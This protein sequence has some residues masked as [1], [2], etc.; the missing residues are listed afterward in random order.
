VTPLQRSLFGEGDPS[1][2]DDAAF[3]RI[4][5]DERA[6]VDVARAYLRGSDTLFD[7]LV[8]HVAW[9][10]GQRWMYER[11]VDD[12]RLSRW[13][14]HEPFPHRSLADTKKA[15]QRRY[16][17]P[18]GGVG[19]NYYRDGRDSVAFHRDREL[20]HLDDT[21]ICI[22][23]LGAQRPFLV[24]PRGGGRSLDLSPASGDLLV[25]G[26]TCQVDWEHGV[27]KVARAGPRISASYRWSSKKGQPD[28]GPSWKAPRRFGGYL[29]HP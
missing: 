4:Q 15:L 26:G 24:R 8:E 18:L 9:K 7:F 21:L 13:Y 16:R 2:A 14:T 3:E 22:V 19:L 1:V 28:R 6:W 29:R 23:T 20:R 10:Q 12:P 5:L 11:M 25:M 27:P 17:V